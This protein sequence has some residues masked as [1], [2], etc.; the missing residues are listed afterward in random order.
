MDVFIVMIATSIAAMQVDMRVP[1][2]IVLVH[3]AANLRC[4]QPTQADE[5]DPDKDEPDQPLTPRRHQVDR[6][7][8][9]KQQRDDRENPHPAG[10]ADPPEQAHPPCLAPLINRRR[11]DRRQMVRRPKNT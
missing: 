6:Q 2:A 8:L 10:V 5:A 3:M 4:E 1:P 9:A 7:C 11:C